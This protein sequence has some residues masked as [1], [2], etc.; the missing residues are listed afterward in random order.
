M[1]QGLEGAP[2]F[3][4]DAK[5][6][7]RPRPIGI[8]RYRVLARGILWLSERDSAKRQPDDQQF[9]KHHSPSGRDILLK[10]FCYG[11]RK[12]CKKRVRW[13]VEPA[14]GL[15]LEADLTRPSPMRLTHTSW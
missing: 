11:A 14:G 4:D 13:I 12:R 5:W 2:T 10:W 9:A 6:R 8:I 7:E 1:D 15:E 3:P